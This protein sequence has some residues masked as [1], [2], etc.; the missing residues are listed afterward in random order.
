VFVDHARSGDPHMQHALI[1]ARARAC[2]CV[3]LAVVAVS[4]S[5]STDVTPPPP[6]P[7]P[8]PPALTN[9]IVFVSDRTMTDQIWVMD[10]DG[11][12]QRQLT[13]SSEQKYRPVF[14]PDGRKIAYTAGL[15]EAGGASRIHIMNS[16]G[17][18]DTE[19]VGGPWVDFSPSW[20]PDGTQLAFTSTRDGDNEIYVMNVDGTHVTNLTKNP[21][22][23]Y[24][25]SWSSASGNIL[26]TSSRGSESTPNIY[27]MSSTGASVD[28]VTIGLNAEWSPTGSKFLFVRSGQI[29]V[30]ASTY[31]S[32]VTDIAP[33]R[34][35][36]GV[37]RWSPDEHRIAFATTGDRGNEIWTINAADGSDPQRVSGSGQDNY[38]DYDPGWTRH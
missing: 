21:R 25:P 9:S 23:D 8:P 17:T 20:S 24:V 14:S 5:G 3:T 34:V 26:F 2:A 35:A 32:S 16:D 38:D 13:T 30:S 7:P 15:I 19:F 33:T 11:S 29:F 28:S 22:S 10:A 4:C 1:I 31:G 18:E 6:P 12:N 37:P 36:F 27:V